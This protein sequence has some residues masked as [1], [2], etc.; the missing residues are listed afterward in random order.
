LG[1]ARSLGK[2]GIPTW[3]VDTDKSKSIAQFSRYTKRFIVSQ[4]PVA[5]LLLREGR[6][7]NLDGWVVFPVS[8]QYVESVA[9][10]HEALKAIYRLTT[11]STY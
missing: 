5:E 9:A 7:H 3:V 1:V 10:S 11:P 8:D 2:R 4:E 6:E